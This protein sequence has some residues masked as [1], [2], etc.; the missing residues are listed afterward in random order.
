VADVIT[1]QG[2]RFPSA[3]VNEIIAGRLTMT[4]LRVVCVVVRRRH[5]DRTAAVSLSYSEL[6]SE[7]GLRPSGSLRATVIRLVKAGVLVVAQKGVGRRPTSYVV[8]TNPQRWLSPK[9]RCRTG[10][11]SLRAIAKN[12]PAIE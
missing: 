6:A 8:Q 3:M 1:E 10:F 12:L 7:L 4:E 5:R 2:L 11:H 9:A